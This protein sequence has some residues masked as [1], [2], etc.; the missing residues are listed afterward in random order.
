MTV[1]AERMNR[2]VRQLTKEELIMYSLG[3]S[4]DLIYDMSR[5]Q[6]RDF[7]MIMNA[8]EKYAKGHLFSLM[9]TTDMYYEYRR[10]E[11]PFM[12]RKDKRTTK[13]SDPAVAPFT[14]TH[15]AYC[16]DRRA[17]STLISVLG[18]VLPKSATLGTLGFR[19]LLFGPQFRQL[20]RAVSLGNSLRVLSFEN[21]DIR[22][23]GFALLCDAMKRPG[24]TSLTCQGCGLS[25]T[26]IVPL[27][28]LLRFQVS[29]QRKSDKEKRVCAEGNCLAKLDLRDNE[30]TSRL[31]IELSDILS[32][33]RMTDL[34]VRNNGEMDE[35]VLEDL[36]RTVPHVK[37]LEGEEVAKRVAKLR[38]KAFG[39]MQPEDKRRH[40][41]HHGHCETEHKRERP[42]AKHERH[43]SAKKPSECGS[44]E[45]QPIPPKDDAGSDDEIQIGQDIRI[46]GSRAHDFVKYL[47]EVCE[48][49]AAAR[50][51]K[52]GKKGGS[53]NKRKV[54]KQKTLRR[55]PPGLSDSLWPF[56]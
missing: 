40:Q 45:P 33:L 36:R 30:F 8:I 41:H 18:E 23:N 56:Y 46:K 24:I 37:I 43:I 13:G 20:S 25:D 9:F 12:K 49:T 5:I 42:P 4:D 7:A 19:A 32:D 44:P 31:L 22:D 52:A 35:N 39:G 34:D 48:M 1:K 54:P 3:N 10:S 50:G 2:Q 26:S 29:L 51:A 21:C 28:D 17:I 16:E 55:S 27:C 15:S 38:T 11:Y 53:P 14:L 6:T 47:L